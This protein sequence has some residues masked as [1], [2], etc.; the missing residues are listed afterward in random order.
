[1]PYA[2]LP[3]GPDDTMACAPKSL[4]EIARGLFAGRDYGMD[5]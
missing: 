4:Q 1:M 2:H 5:R 3:D